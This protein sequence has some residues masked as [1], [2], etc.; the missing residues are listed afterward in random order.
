MVNRLNL[1]SNILGSIESV[2][3]IIV[4]SKNILKILEERGELLRSYS[5]APIEKYIVSPAL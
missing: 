2:N 1:L 3:K 5:F 4:G